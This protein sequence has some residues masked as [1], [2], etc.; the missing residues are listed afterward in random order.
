MKINVVDWPRIYPKDYS[1]TST[2]TL[3]A[4]ELVRNQ[5]VT[6]DD[7]FVNV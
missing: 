2:Q 1:S 3:L 6:E 5:N 7:I 4:S